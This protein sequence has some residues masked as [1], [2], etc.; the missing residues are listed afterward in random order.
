MLE[1]KSGSVVHT[2]TYSYD[3]NGNMLTRGHDDES[4]TYEYDL[5][6]L[7][8]K[9]TDKQSATDT[10]PKVTTYTYT[11]RGDVLRQTKGNGNTRR[12]HLLPGLDPAPAGGEKV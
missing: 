12:L 1:K 11:S 7:L 4:A 2:T 5:R 8:A 9:V 10:S 6:D 3:E